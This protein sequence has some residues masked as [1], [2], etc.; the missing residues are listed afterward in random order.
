MTKAIGL[1]NI[2][3]SNDNEDAEDYKEVSLAG[4]T[5]HVYTGLRDSNIAR[6]PISG[7]SYVIHS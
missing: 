6:P 4:T 5:D 1:R 2:S 7:R 3:S